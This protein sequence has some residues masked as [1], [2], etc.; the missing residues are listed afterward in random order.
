MESTEDVGGG[1]GPIR[2]VAGDGE[3]VLAIS[4]LTVDFVGR[5]GTV[6]AVR[7][8]SFAV[9]RHEIV[10]V[11]GESGSGKSVTAMAT[12]RLLPPTARVS[13]SVRLSGTDLSSLGEPEMRAVRG[14][15]IGMVFQ[16]PMR[17][18]N[19]VFT[20][21]WQVAEAVK[22]HQPGLDRAELRDRAALLLRRA[23]IAD[24][25]RR[26]G[27]YPH[28][29]SGGLRQ[30]VMIAMAVANEPELLIADEATTALDVTVQAEILEL[31]RE[32]RA[33]TGMAVLVIT[34]NMG[35]VADVADRVVVMRQGEIVE[36]APVEQL[37][38][39]PEHAYT[40]ELLASVPRRGRH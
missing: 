19:P 14:A 3:P 10:A 38:A 12:M 23:G 34:H 21:G 5:S 35:V 7:G 25:D 31:F 24:T 2:P 32:L 6:H 16:D 28:E 29:L 11:V 33:R 18:L 39:R 27:Q 30:R 1:G 26:L 17:A 15:R 36:Q 9:E 13:G 4:S 37:F 8:V 20:V 40:A 22:L